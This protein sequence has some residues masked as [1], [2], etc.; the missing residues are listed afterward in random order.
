MTTETNPELEALV[1]EGDEITLST[2]TRITVERLKTRQLFKFV[3]IL[4]SGAGQI[5]ANLDFGDIED[6]AA[7]AGQLLAVTLVAI[8]D[9]E[10]ESIDFIQS[11]VRPVGVIEKPRTAKERESNEA[12]YDAIAE[13]LDNP[14]LDDLITIFTRVVTAEAPHIQALGKRLAGLLATAISGLAAKS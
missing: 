9:A 7:F 12:L 11:M 8:P 13:E 14:E 4:T 2:G 10:D 3:K 6:G 1:A 5:L